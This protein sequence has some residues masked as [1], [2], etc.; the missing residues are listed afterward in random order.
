MYKSVGWEIKSPI[1]KKWSWKRF[2]YVYEMQIKRAKPIEILT[3]VENWSLKN[4][5]Q[6]EFC[7]TDTNGCNHK[8]VFWAEY[9]F[10]A[11]RKEFEKWCKEIENE[12]KQDNGKNNL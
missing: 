12:N 9:G 2:M 3:Y 11:D 1:E 4:N 8:K 5:I 10:N 6:Y 7:Y